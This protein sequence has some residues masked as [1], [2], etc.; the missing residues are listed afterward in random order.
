M[1]SAIQYPLFIVVIVIL[2]SSPCL[3]WF[4]ARGGF[5]LFPIGC[6]PHRPWKPPSGEKGIVAEGSPAISASC[7]VLLTGFCFHQL[8]RLIV[9]VA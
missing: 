7:L 6:L 1:H 9:A 5:W 3:L 4:S 2:N 8:V